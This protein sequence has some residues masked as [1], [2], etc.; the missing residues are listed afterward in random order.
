MPI[1]IVLVLRKIYCSNRTMD[2]INPLG[3][4]V[5]KVSEINQ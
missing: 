5:V 3:F 2:D 1:K 4:T